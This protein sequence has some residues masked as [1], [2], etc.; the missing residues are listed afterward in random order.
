MKASVIVSALQDVTK[1]WSKQRKSEE[2]NASARRRRRQSMT[3]SQTVTLK[4]AVWDHIEAAYDAVGNGGRL[5]A[6]ARQIMYDVRRRI[7]R[8]T[9]KPLN[10]SYFTQT[11]L[12]AFMRETPDAD[13]WDVV[14]DARGHF[15]EPHTKRGVALGTLDVRQYLKGSPKHGEDIG[16]RPGDLYPTHGPDNRFGAI[17]FLEKEG[18]GPLLKKTKLAERFD[19]GLMSTKGMSVTASRQLV[20]EL[21]GEHDIPLLVLRDFD[22]AGF[23]IVRSFTH[24]T[25]R[26]QFS[27]DIRVIDLGLRLADVKKWNLEP[28]SFSAKG[29]TSAMKKNL[30]RNGATK[31]EIEFIATNRQRVELNAFRSADLIDFIEAKLAEHG[32]KK[33]VPDAA[34]LEA[35]YR[36]TLANEYIKRRFDDLKDEAQKFAD[37]AKV[38]ALKRK[39]TK[40]LA[41]SP[42][43]PWDEAV[44]SFAAEAAAEQDDLA[45]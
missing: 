38:P 16:F 9:D 31:D 39:L 7:Q 6:H 34:T 21:C 32:I 3:R 37:A 2:R 13:D 4:D 45:C 36:H 1:K 20:D 24:D 25:D 28:E 35:A 33:V 8:D 43:Q 11:L 27:H 14:Y 17:L 41:D 22:K 12:P 42:A 26:Y 19:I 15:T 44:A 40:N 10:D 23:S 29:S 30:R 5:P 18:F